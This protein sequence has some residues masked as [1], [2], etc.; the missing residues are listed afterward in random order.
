MRTQGACGRMGRVWGSVPPPPG[1]PAVRGEALR[2]EEKP[3]R[4]KRPFECG[5]L[6]SAKLEL[7]PQGMIQVFLRQ[8]DRDKS[9][10]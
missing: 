8:A 4:A 1:G 5:T 3:A 9:L 7:V 6:S 2:A 10:G